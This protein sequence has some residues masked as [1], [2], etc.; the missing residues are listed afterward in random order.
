[1]KTV[2]DENGMFPRTPP[3]AVFSET[4]ERD[5]SQNCVT[6]QNCL[7]KECA[8]RVEVFLEEERMHFLHRFSRM[9]SPGTF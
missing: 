1:M 5:S 8:L 4:M 2:S 9:S 6:R 3:A 7:R